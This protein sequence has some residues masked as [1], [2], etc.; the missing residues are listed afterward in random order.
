MSL[1][2]IKV[3][4]PCPKKMRNMKKKKKKKKK[5]TVKKTIE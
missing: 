1:R 2:E 4:I 3:N 5:A